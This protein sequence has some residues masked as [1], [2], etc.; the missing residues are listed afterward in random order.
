VPSSTPQAKRQ[1]SRVRHN[2][3]FLFLFFKKEILPSFA[4]VPSSQA[5]CRIIRA[6]AIENMVRPLQQR[7]HRLAACA[8]GRKVVEQ[9]FRPRARAAGG[10]GQAED[11]APTAGPSALKGRAKERA[12]RT[13]N[14]PS[15]RHIRIV[16]ES[17]GVQHGFAP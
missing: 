13:E 8:F 12:A 5:E 2:K 14:N 7:R 3:S 9:S 6:G 11:R 17:E 1:G 4:D 15:L 10:R 16:T